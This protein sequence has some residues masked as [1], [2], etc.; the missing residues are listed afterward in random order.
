MRRLSLI[1]LSLV[2]LTLSACGT[3]VNGQSAEDHE[4]L[5]AEWEVKFA[6]QK[7]NGVFSPFPENLEEGAE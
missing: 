6:A 4:R 5:N 2:V 7:H 3:M 1:L